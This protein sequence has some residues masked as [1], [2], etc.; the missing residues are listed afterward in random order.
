MRLKVST[1]WSTYVSLS[2]LDISLSQSFLVSR[3]ECFK[4]EFEMQS[5][6]FFGSRKLC[7][8]FSHK[9]L[10]LKYVDVISST[11]FDFYGIWHAGQEVD[12]VAEF[13]LLAQNPSFYEVS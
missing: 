6:L 4:D 3:D 10:G 1:N 11:V 13:V 9:M 8:E 2:I 7:Y 12:F 5:C